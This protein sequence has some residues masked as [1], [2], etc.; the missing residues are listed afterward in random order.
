MK[1]FLK[2]KK[3]YYNFIVIMR[4]IQVIGLL[5]YQKFCVNCVFLKL[6]IKKIA[7]NTFKYYLD[8][9]FYRPDISDSDHYYRREIPKN[10]K[11]D[12]CNNKVL[13]IGKKET[14]EKIV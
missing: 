6:L 13:T 11:D 4:K 9:N 7:L 14:L 5:D 10:K 2:I 8:D 1:F 12:I 3:N